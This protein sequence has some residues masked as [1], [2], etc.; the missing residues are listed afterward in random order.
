VNAAK[1]A[2]GHDGNDIAFLHFRF[3]VVDNGV[4]I[5]EGHRRFALKLYV[6]DEFVNIENF[7]ELAG[8]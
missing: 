1:A 5:G 2:V 4:G 3:E 7:A 8:L 6:A